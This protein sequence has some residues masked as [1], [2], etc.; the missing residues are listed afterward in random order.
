MCVIKTLHSWF[1]LTNTKSVSHLGMCI[2]CRM[3]DNNFL[4]YQAL[5]YLDPKFTKLIEV[6]Q[7]S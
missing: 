4:H 6:I 3:L 5:T 2:L 7:L 1:H